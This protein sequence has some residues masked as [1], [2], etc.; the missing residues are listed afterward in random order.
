MSAELLKRPRGKRRAVRMGI[1]MDAAME[2]EIIRL[3]GACGYM[4]PTT[5]AYICV[6]RCIES[7]EFVWK[8]Q[9]EY[10]TNRDHWLTHV[11]TDG[12][13]RLEALGLGPR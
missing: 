7:T 10:N 2:R 9:A 5:L 8:I 11:E 3:S 12:V 4:R 6:K 13:R 1:S